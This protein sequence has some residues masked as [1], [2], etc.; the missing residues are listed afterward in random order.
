MDASMKRAADGRVPLVADALPDARLRRRGRPV[1]RPVR[2]LLLQGLPGRRPRPRHRLGA[3]VRRGQAPDR[4]D[5]GQGGGP[6][7]GARHRH[8]AERRRA[9]PSSPATAST[10]CPTASS[11]PARTRTPTEGEIAF[12]FPATYGGREVSGVKFRFEGGKVVDASAELG[13]DFLLEML[14]TDPGARILGELGIGTNYG[15]STGTKEILLDEK[16]GGTVHMAIGAALPRVGRHERL[17]RALGHGLRP[18]QGRLDHGRRGDVAARRTLRRLAPALCNTA[19]ARLRVP[20]QACSAPVHLPATRNRAGR[21][22][23]SQAAR[24]G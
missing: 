21:R 5:P 11:S 20:L 22:R 3:P 10:T 1:A 8:Q 13:E 16:I 24:A 15:I 23:R 12:S 7:Q 2:G 17:G 19:L 4:V 6:H 9:A 18:A 14:D